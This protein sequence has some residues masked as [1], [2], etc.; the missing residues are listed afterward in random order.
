MRAGSAGAGPVRLGLM[1]KLN[2]A[3][4]WAHLDDKP[5]G[6][7]GDD[8]AGLGVLRAAPD[9]RVAPRAAS[10]GCA[11]ATTRHSPL[12]M[13]ILGGCGTPAR[14]WTSGRR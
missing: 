10:A 13:A 3:R 2:R 1:S 11:M 14:E 8:G 9:T 7:S 12:F 6:S 5:L 4:R